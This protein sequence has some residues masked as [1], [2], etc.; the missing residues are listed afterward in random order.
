MLS[1]E[2]TKIIEQKRFLKYQNE[3]KEVRHIKRVKI[4][5]RLIFLLTMQTFLLLFFLSQVFGND[6]I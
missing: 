1:F 4:F 2:T 5:F 6:G 3:Q